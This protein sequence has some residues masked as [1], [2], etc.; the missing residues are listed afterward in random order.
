MHYCTI[1]VQI[2][3]IHPRMKYERE[4]IGKNRNLKK[5]QREKE[6]I[7][8]II[9]IIMLLLLLLLLTWVRCSTRRQMRTFV[10]ELFFC[11]Q[12]SC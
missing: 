10:H 9:V 8:L 5:M 1:T 7:V 6:V 4:Q 12:I 11:S 2:K 3:N